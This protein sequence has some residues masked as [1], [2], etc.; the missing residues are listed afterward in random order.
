CRRC[1]AW[2]SRTPPS[3]S[4]PG[5]PPACA[6]SPSSGDWSPPRSSGTPRKSSHPSTEPRDADSATL[7]EVRRTKIVATLGPA[8][9]S[10]ERVRAMVE[11]GMDVARLNFSHGDH[12]THR[13][14]FEWVRRASEE[15]GRN[16]AVLQDIQGPKL[17]VGRF[18]DGGIEL[19]PGT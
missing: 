14:W 8:T 5:A 10:Y 1:G 7:P 6:S 15:T 17:R 18:P 9:D 3:G 19:A 2:W 13:R 16:V 4:A 11:A 12:D